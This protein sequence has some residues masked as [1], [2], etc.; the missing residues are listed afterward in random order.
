MFLNKVY[1]TDGKQYKLEDTIDFSSSN[2][3]VS[4]IKA[5]T[6][7][8]VE[9]TAI[10]YEDII[11]VDLHIKCKVIGVSS[12]SLKEVPLNLDFNDSLDFSETDDGELNFEPGVSI[13]LDPYVLALILSN[14]PIR[15]VG[16][17]EKL[18]ENGTA[19]SVMTEEQFYE[20]KKNKKDSRWDALDKL[21]L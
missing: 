16:K 9:L 11:H 1:L 7:C 8:N 10:S 12:Y 15:I 19:Y 18:P 2:F 6:D 21:D 20:Q 4:H 13:D 17:G 3:D 5:I 14:V